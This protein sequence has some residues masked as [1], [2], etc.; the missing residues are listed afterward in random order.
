MKYEYK[1]MKKVIFTILLFV[2]L[3]SC[4][5][6]QPLQTE[7]TTEMQIVALWSTSNLDSVKNYIPLDNAKIVLI[8][9]YG[10]RSEFTDENGLMVLT[11]LPSSIYQIS[12]IGKHPDDSN[13]QIV[14][15]ITDIEIKNEKIVRDTIFA[16]PISAS[17]ISINEIYSGG[18]VN[19]FNFVFDQFIELYNSST[20]VKYLDGMQVF[21]FSGTDNGTKG[22]GADWSN[23]GDID[24]VTYA[25]KFPGRPGDQNYPFEP[26][27]FLT[28]A[29]DAY[30]H[31]NSVG[32]SINLSNADWEFVN[33]FN[34][35]D[36][37][38]PNVP[39][40]ESFRLDD[41]HDFL[42]R[43]YNDIVIIANGVDTVWE[44]GIDLETILDGVE[45]QANLSFILTLDDRIDR[46]WILNPPIY[47]GQSMQRRE[48]GVDT[49]NGTL[50][51]ET[52]PTS[53]PGRQ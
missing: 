15:N 13:I 26:N 49:N 27:T 25:F 45:Y 9:E 6:D 20:E 1:T 37:D 14:G 10:E 19:S 39:N 35:I 24:G 32:T 28:L 41:N 2:I 8:S 48:K 34:A 53:T 21:R 12:A 43:T 31:R 4:Q 51:W 44:D 29:S 11:D 38:N 16:K 33:Q 18:P 52:I 7:G 30:D 42:I 17:G 3:F 46:G 50:D 22:P 23:D 40:L 5:E 36:F 47:T